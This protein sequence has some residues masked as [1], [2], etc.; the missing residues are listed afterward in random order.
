M[1]FFTT[2][3]KL[4]SYFC[5]IAHQQNSLHRHPSHFYIIRNVCFRKF[6]SSLGDQWRQHYNRSNVPIIHQNAPDLSQGIPFEYWKDY[7]EEQINGELQ[8]G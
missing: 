7:A 2:R 1:N 5:L 8:Q 4:P 6:S 3:N